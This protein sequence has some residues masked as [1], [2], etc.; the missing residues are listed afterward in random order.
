[1][2]TYKIKNAIFDCANWVSGSPPEMHVTVKFLI[3]R[4]TTQRL[5]D[6]DKIELLAFRLPSPRGVSDTADR[7]ILAGAQLCVRVENLLFALGQ[8]HSAFLSF[9]AFS[10][11][12]R[13]NESDLSLAKAMVGMELNATGTTGTRHRKS[14]VGRVQEKVFR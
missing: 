1:M 12:F 14:V 4:V 13:M 5:H 7:R 9:C 8:R 3:M 11:V 6:Q 2:R 10:F